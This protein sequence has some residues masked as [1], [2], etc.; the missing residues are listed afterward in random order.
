MLFSA[1]MKDRSD[2]FARLD[3]LMKDF[4]PCIDIGVILQPGPLDVISFR[5]GSF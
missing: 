2:V 3:L 5:V 1:M 4:V